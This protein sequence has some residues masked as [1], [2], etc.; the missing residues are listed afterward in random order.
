MKY[1]RMRKERISR[2]WTHEY[3]GHQIGITKAAYSNIENDN[4]KPS[5]EVLCKLENL[6]NLS[7]REL[8]AAAD[9]TN[10]SPK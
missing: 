9:E 10:P 1:S 2:N 3:V 7:H 4:C 8:F 6:F 5:Y